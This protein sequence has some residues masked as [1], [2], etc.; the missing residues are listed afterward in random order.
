MRIEVS[1]LKTLA[2]GSV[3]RRLWSSTSGTSC[4]DGRP[5]RENTRCASSVKT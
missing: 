4:S 3:L 5:N 1:G 2:I